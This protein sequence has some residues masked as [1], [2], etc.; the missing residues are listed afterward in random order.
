VMKEI[1]D[2]SIDLVVTDPPYGVGTDYGGAEDNKTNLKRLID[3]FMPEILR[4]AKVILLT[5]G[6]GNQ[7]LYPS[8]D[9]TLAWIYR[10]GANQCSWGFNTWQP[11]LAYGKCPYRSSNMGARPDTIWKEE[12]PVPNGHPCPKPIMF[13]KLLLLR[14]SVKQSDIIFDP[15]LGSGT[16]AVAA[17]Q[18]GRRW[19]GIEINPGYCKIAEQ[20]LAQGEMKLR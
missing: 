2:N 20:R 8:P 1:P 19:I 14:G 11:I 13:W 3:S 17:K 16:T 7:Q 18:L 5:P 9:W 6:N 12:T 4:I 15:F 10:G